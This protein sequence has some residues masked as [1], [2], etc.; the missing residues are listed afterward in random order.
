MFRRTVTLSRSIAQRTNDETVKNYVDR[1]LKAATRGPRG[2]GWTSKVAR[3][4]PPTNANGLW[5]FTR[6]VSFEKTTGHQSKAPKQWRQICAA[7]IQA[8][9]AAVFNKYPWL[10]AG[11]GV[12]EIYAELLAQDKVAPIG[13]TKPQNKSGV[14]VI[15]VKSFGSVC[16]D[17]GTYFDHIYNRDD[18]IKILH[19]AVV[20]ANESDF[21]NRFH[22]VLYGPPA[23]GKSDILI[24]LGNMLGKENEAFMKLDATS[25]T[26]AGAQK[27]LLEASY[28]PP[29]LIVEEIE[30]TDEK[31]LRWLLGILDQRAEIRKTNFH[32]GHKARHVKMLCLATVNDIQL[33]KSVMSG[34]LHSRFAHEIYCPRPD[35]KIMQKILEREIK[36]TNGKD[37]WIEPA[38]QFCM[39]DQG[40]DD[41]RKI[42]PICLC[43]G[44]S[45]L[46]GSYQKSVLAVQPPA[47][48]ALN[49]GGNKGN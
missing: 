10:V 8:G 40:W 43:G 35:R 23:C 28:I 44:D 47:R 29:V 3:V 32:I 27:I 39:D 12:D 49:L 7:L 18:Q 13:D 17:K 30:K 38:L 6:K 20:A 14:T 4:T 5:V 11:E 15:S 48:P 16:T 25:T 31:S 2:H 33:F 21:T 34:A 46:D 9:Q 41:P 42:V 19:S 45:L 22:S 24:S 26:E 37:E 36:K 1:I